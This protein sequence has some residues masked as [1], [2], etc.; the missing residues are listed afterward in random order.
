[1]RDFNFLARQTN[2][3]VCLQERE[4]AN[5]R[6]FTLITCSN[7]L[8]VRIGGFRSQHYDA[9]TNFLGKDEQ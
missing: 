7:E 6:E 2:G 1:M 9:P 8:F 3:N 5:L 4:S